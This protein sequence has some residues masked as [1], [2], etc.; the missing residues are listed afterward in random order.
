[1]THLVNGG[2]GQT[3][4]CQTLLSEGEQV[5]PIVNP[6]PDPEPTEYGLP[7]TDLGP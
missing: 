6:A 2:R 3:G 1:M 4:R 5:E 7:L